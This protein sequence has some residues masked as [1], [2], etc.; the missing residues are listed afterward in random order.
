MHVRI[1]LFAAAAVLA[2][3][4]SPATAAPDT[5][6]EALF[7][8]KI[9]FACHSVTRGEVKRLGPYVA[10]IAQKYRERP[11]AK[12]YL[13]KKVLEGSSGVWGP[14]AASVMPANKVTE[15]EAQALVEW[16]LSR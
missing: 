6:A 7:A 13:Q 12:G 16:I 11:D 4:A 5:E 9:C 2:V 1:T 8:S 15:A 3:A 14:A 10:D